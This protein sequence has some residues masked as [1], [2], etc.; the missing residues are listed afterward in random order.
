MPQKE[1]KKAI[2]ACLRSERKELS[3]EKKV[4]FLIF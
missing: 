2:G 1:R 4:A 3:V